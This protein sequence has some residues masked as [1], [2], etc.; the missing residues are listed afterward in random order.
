MSQTARVQRTTAAASL[1]VCAVLTVISTPLMPDFSGGFTDRL[2]AVAAAGTSATVSALLFTIAQPFFAIGFIGVARVLQDRAP[3]LAGLGA[4][5]AVLSAFGHS[6]YGGVGL[7]MIDMAKDPANHDAYAAV[8]AAGET[9]L[10]IPFLVM[11]LLG[12]ILAL[13]LVAATLW[14]ARVGAR[15]LPAVL[16]GFV[17]VEFAGS[18]LSEWAVYAAGLLYLVGF[19]ALAQIVTRH[20]AAGPTPSVEY[21]DPTL[22]RAEEIEHSTFGERTV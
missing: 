9:G 20:L 13:F 11:G 21:S 5:A 7:T 15:W 12:T 4:A 17:V 1:V 6:V 10:M 18:A 19:L 14:R 3:V 16:V 8:L 2:E 22:E